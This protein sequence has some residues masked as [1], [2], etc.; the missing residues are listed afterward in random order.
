[1]TGLVAGGCNIVAFTTGRGSCYGCKPA[2]S[3]KIATN[4]PMYERMIDDMDLNAGVILEGV[5]VEEAGRQIFELMLEVA[6]GRKTKSELHGLGDEE[7][8]P[9]SIGPTL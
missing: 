7:F 3:I 9:W 6:S 1:M 4:T 2:P 5:S 8:A